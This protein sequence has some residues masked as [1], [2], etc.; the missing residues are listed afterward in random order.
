MAKEVP[1]FLRA[2]QGVEKGIDEAG[3]PWPK[4]PAIK[5]FEFLK[6]LMSRDK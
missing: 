5:R 6:K 1:D 2:C 4:G 3:W